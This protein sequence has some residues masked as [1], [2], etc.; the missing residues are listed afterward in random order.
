MKIHLRLLA[1]VIAL[2]SVAPLWA[3]PEEQYAATST[4]KQTEKVSLD[5]ISLETGYVFESDLNHGGNFGKQDALQN[6]FWIEPFPSRIDSFHSP[7]NGS[8][9]LAIELLINN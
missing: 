9:G 8:G 4:V 3:G 1:L 2:F 5:L 6:E 7:P